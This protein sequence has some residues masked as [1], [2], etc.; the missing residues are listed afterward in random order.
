M[1]WSVGMAD[2]DPESNRRTRKVPL[3][4]QNS[5]RDETSHASAARA[6]NGDGN[7]GGHGERR[8][9]QQQQAPPQEEDERV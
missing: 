3:A 2:R 1:M 8:Q 6:L 5:D 9:R 7:E 4:Q